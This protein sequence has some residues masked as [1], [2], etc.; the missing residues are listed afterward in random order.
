MAITMMFPVCTGSR[1]QPAAAALA[2]SAI[3]HAANNR[4]TWF[5]RVNEEVRLFVCA[6]FVC[7]LFIYALVFSLHPG[8]Q[9]RYVHARRR[10]GRPVSV[11]RRISLQ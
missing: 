1:A 11:I 4:F 7:A 8:G 9:R 2:S 3:T 10:R 6:L 5:L